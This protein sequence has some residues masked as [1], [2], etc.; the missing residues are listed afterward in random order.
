MNILLVYS[1]KIKSRIFF[2]LYVWENK[3]SQNV[4]ILVYCILKISKVNMSYK[5]II[6]GTVNNN[7]RNFKLL[8]INNLKTNKGKSNNWPQTDQYINDI[9]KNIWIGLEKLFLTVKSIA[10]FLIENNII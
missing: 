7:L 1:L 5:K 8:Y 4:F 10:H 9:L 3:F 2:K 6:N